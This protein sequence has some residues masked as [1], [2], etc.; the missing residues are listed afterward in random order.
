M[1]DE[2]TLSTNPLDV[3]HTTSCG[4]TWTM[5]ATACPE[6]FVSLRKDAARFCGENERLQK[7]LA[8]VVDRYVSLV[9][10]GDCGNWN[11]E[12]EEAVIAARA[13]IR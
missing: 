12:E 9:N 8:A 1:S 11:P 5:R 10:S 13:L 7:A 3:E 6:C 4:H 2:Q